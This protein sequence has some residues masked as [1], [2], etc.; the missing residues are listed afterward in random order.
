MYPTYLTYLTYPLV[1][2]ILL[3]LL[4]LFILTMLC[5]LLLSLF[6]GRVIQCYVLF[7]ISSLSSSMSSF[8]SVSSSVSL[9]SSCPFVAV[10][11]SIYFDLFTAP[12]RS[13]YLLSP[14]VNYGRPSCSRWLRRLWRWFDDLCHYR[15]FSYGTLYLGS[16]R[17]S[18]P[19][20]YGCDG[21]LVRRRGPR[22]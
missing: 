8:P 6:I 21:T 5:D 3:I 16:P 7:L 15:S 11:C 18:F 22:L 17:C 1:V 20:A 10:F 9:S 13:C 14:T 12:L 2:L 4:I 19:M